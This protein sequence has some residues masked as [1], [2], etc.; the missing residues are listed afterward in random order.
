MSKFFDFVWWL[1]MAPHLKCKKGGRSHLFY[2]PYHAQ[3][4]CV[5]DG[6]GRR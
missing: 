5:G 6:P 4:I 1:D 2:H 3:G